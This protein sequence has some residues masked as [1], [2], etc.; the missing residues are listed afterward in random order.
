M[1]T[2]KFFRRYAAFVA[3]GISPDRRSWSALEPLVVEAKVEDLVARG[4]KRYMAMTSKQVMDWTT[5]ATDNGIRDFP[6]AG[7]FPDGVEGPGAP[8]EPG[9]E[10][11]SA[12]LFM[13]RSLL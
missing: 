13:R 4:V 7:E 8:E 9:V 12:F 3:L 5:H 2:K 10:P 6:A 11:A 1:A